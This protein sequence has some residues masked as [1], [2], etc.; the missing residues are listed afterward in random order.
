MQRSDPA[1]PDPADRFDDLIRYDRHDHPFVDRAAHLSLSFSGPS[2]VGPQWLHPRAVLATT[3]RLEPVLKPG[4]YTDHDWL[5]LHR[6]ALVSRPCEAIESG[7]SGDVRVDSR[8]W[9]SSPRTA[10]GRFTV[11]NAGDAAR[12]LRLAW[13]G[14]ALPDDS[15]HML[16]LFPGASPAAR[17]P[18]VSA[19]DA[20]YAI[21]WLPEGGC[22]LPSLGL[23]VQLLGEDP[24]ADAWC[25][26]LPWHASRE[27]AAGGL[28]YAFVL[29]PTTLG[30]SESRSFD[31]AVQFHAANWHGELPAFEELAADE[32]ADA[33]AAN[34]AA[35]APVLG[36]DA[37]PLVRRARLSLHRCSLRGLNG[38]FGDDHASLCTAN[39]L[40]FSSTFFWDSLF[41]SSALAGLDPELSRGAIRVLFCRQLAFDGSCQEQQWNFGVGFRRPQQSPQSPLVAWA[42]NRHLERHD[43]LPFAAD[44]YD[45]ALANLDFWTNFSDAD[46]DGLS[47]YRWSGQIADNSPLWDRYNG[48]TGHCCWLPP[49]ASVQLNCFRYREALELALIADDLGKT[50]EAADLRAQAVAIAARLEEICYVPADH[51]FWDFNHQTQHHTRARTFWMFWPLWAGLPLEEPARRHLLDTLLD[52]KQFFGPIPFP[53]TAYDEPTYDPTGYWRG[54][55]WPHISCWLVEVLDRHGHAAEADEAARRL[56]RG[57]T[58]AGGPGENLSTDV[59]RPDAGHP[60]YNWGCAA[61]LHLAE[62]LGRYEPRFPCRRRRLAKATPLAS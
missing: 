9:F 21:R 55:A 10:R 22:D 56:L 6:D 29:P 47:E 28:N 20:A 16:S 25:G 33:I 49:V 2:T 45:R 37:D 4:L 32:P 58:L 53:S 42:I 5:P 54:R 34:R 12:E 18:H 36:D 60:N 39:A 31:F 11:R 13:L 3:Q 41:T 23:R 14:A 35:V 48:D 52:P 62:R 26:D 19:G 30:P 59:N 24:D 61:V 51:A 40:G 44:L 27:P 7:G 1:D 46:R 43:D 17:T 15:L 50:G 57:W 38:L 8:W